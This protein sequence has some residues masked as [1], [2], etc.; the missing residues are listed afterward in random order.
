ML[1]IMVFPNK[2]FTNNAERT[3]LRLEALRHQT[4]A[5]T[6]TIIFAPENNLYHYANALND[7]LMRKKM[8]D[9]NLIDEED[10]VILPQD[11]LLCNYIMYRMSAADFE[12]PVRPCHIG[13]HQ[14][15]RVD[16]PLLIRRRTYRHFNYACY[17]CRDHGHQGSG[18]ICG[19]SAGHVGA[20][21]RYWS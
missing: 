9:R 1:D 13:S 14:G 5:R 10:R 20:H 12:Y 15:K 3:I 16:L 6:A 18:G 19:S 21:T 8:F 4:F 2:D 11:V 7:L 17:L